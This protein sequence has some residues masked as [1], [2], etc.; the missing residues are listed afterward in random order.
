MKD[1]KGCLVHEGFKKA[2]DQVKGRVKDTV[3]A[4]K[5]H[6]DKKT[7]RVVVTGY[8][9]GAAVATLM[10][11]ELRAN[12]V[13]CD[14]YTYGS[15]RVGNAE[16]VK[17]ATS[18]EGFSARITNGRDLVAA[19][20]VFSRITESNPT[21]EHIFPEYWY[22]NGLQAETAHNRFQSGLQICESE[23]SCT[24]ARCSPSLSVLHDALKGNWGLG[25]FVKA[26]GENLQKLKSGKPIGCSASDHMA[27]MNQFK[28]CDANPQRRGEALE[29]E[30]KIEDVQESLTKLE[31][32]MIAEVNQTASTP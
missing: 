17:Y 2:L 4:L 21:Y 10:A 28:A 30:Y 25:T 32:E 14:L 11:V 15:P 16:F 24:S 18:Q 31:E 22:P 13:P 1:C 3:D 9:L 26:L 7:W 6:E 19:I 12:K 29:E 27:Y 23:A 5:A 20:P 8:S